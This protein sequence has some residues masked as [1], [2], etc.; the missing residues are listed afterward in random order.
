[1][2]EHVLRF[3][4]EA[5]R[6]KSWPAKHTLKDAVLGHLATKFEMDRDYTEKEINAIIEQWHTFGDYF[7]LRR[8]LVD[9]HFL[10]RTRDG[11]RYWREWALE[12]ETSA[13]PP[14]DTQL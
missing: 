6:I 9:H 13:P 1:M 14:A 8:G 5:G 4:D 11:A 7:L 12:P 2:T 10:S 3:L